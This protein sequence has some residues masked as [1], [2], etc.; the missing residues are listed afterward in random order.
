VVL[1]ASVSLMGPRSGVTEDAPAPGKKLFTDYRCN[2]CHTVEVAGIAKKKAQNE[3]STGDRKP[4]DLSGV[5]RE[6]TA[7]WIVK[8]LGKKETIKGQRHPKKFRGG[9]AD[10]KAMA[11]WLETLETEVKKET[12]D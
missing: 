10:A 2:S 6:R 9:D 11:A 8:Y 7:D 12:V 3:E 4:P 5:G 1:L